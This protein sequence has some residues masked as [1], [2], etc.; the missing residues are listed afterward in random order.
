M[1]IVIGLLLLVAAVVVGTA[2]VLTNDG[3]AHAMTSQFSVFGYHVTGS[4]GML[5]LDGIVVGVVG[6]IGFVL[7]V[8]SARRT[9]RRGRV[10]RGEL[11]QARRDTEAVGRDR[12]Q[13]AAQQ[14]DAVQSNPQTLQPTPGP[15]FAATPPEPSSS[16][17]GESRHRS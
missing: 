5:F 16:V 14:R 7:V 15:S 11:T 8:S 3:N 10:A 13:L 17:A 12:D 1:I 6:L 2:A 4:T 9:A